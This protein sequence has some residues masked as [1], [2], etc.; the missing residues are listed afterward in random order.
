MT[1]E[2]DNYVKI[3]IRFHSNIFDEE[4]TET[5][6]AEVIDE[7]KGIYKIEN[8]PFYA[9]LASDD[10]V[11]A[12][13]DD[14]E[15]MLTFR[16]TMEFSGN[17]IVQV[18]VFDKIKDT[19]SLRKIFEDL[20]CLTEKFQ[21]GYFVIEILSTMNYKPIKLKLDELSNSNVIDYAEPCLSEA[22]RQ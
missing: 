13:Y 22:H 14:T 10:I 8:I 1:T 19:N 15:E 20:G 4:I 16:E 12:E 9:P 5:M 2:T 17:S 3:L 7:T 6:W 11:F 21:D 18:V